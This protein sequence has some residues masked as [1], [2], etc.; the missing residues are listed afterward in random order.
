L[1][2]KTPEVMGLQV[3]PASRTPIFGSDKALEPT[4]KK[5]VANLNGTAGDL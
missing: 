3:V 4:N 2:F 1:G 5:T